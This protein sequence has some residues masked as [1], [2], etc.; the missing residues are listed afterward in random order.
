MSD[1]ASLNNL[2]ARIKAAVQCMMCNLDVQSQQQNLNL[3]ANTI[4]FLIF[5]LEEIEY[6]DS[7]LNI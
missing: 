6:F 1:E 7:K 4:S 2:D 5:K 3:A